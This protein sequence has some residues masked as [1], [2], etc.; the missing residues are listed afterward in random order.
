MA[1]ESKLD[2]PSREQPEK[3][4]PIHRAGSAHSRPSAEAA[5]VVTAVDALHFGADGTILHHMF[6][7]LAPSLDGQ[8][9][10]GIKCPL[11]PNSVSIVFLCTKEIFADVLCERGS[12]LKTITDCPS[13]VGNLILVSCRDSYGRH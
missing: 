12:M 1:T 5:N 10:L 9:N 2:G 13:C 8:S 6:P 11:Q 7:L 4:R 3:H